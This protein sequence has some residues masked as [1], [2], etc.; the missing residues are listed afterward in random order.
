[1]YLKAPA[2]EDSTW[3]QWRA[4]DASFQAPEKAPVFAPTGPLADLGSAVCELRWSEA[5]TQLAA[6]NSG[7]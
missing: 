2:D 4:P 5:G 3:A 1:M 6:A 7:G